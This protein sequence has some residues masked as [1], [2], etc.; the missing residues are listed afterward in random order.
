MEA[1]KSAA[2]KKS[3]RLEGDTEQSKQR[4]QISRTGAA[5]AQ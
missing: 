2:H 3:K 1:P 5:A 4:H